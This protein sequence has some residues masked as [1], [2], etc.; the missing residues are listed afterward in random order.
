MRRTPLVGLVR[1][2]RSN[3]AQGISFVGAF[4]LGKGYGTGPAGE[5][6]E[7]RAITVLL[8][9]EWPPCGLE[10]TGAALDF[11]DLKGVLANVLAGMGLGTDM[12]R[13]RPAPDVRFLHPG[14]ASRIEAAGRTLGVAGA[15]HPK[16]AQVCDLPGEVWVAELDFDGVAFYGPARVV[17]RPIPRFP[18]VTRDIAVVVDE[19]FEAE[20]ILEEIRALH[21]P[22]I[23]SARVFD[24]YR[25]APIPAGRKSLA[26]GIAYRAPDRTLTDDEVNGL[27]ARVRERLRERFRIELRS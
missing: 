19:S 22:L 16:V 18:V 20:A 17:A 3:I 23:E 21:D 4:E 24:C 8:W 13:W 5:R 14:K 25:G 1:A 2:A 26:Y 7:P 6:R 10:R 12:V 15:L 9:G 11:F 27:H